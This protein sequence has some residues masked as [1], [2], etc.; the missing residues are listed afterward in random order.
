MGSSI[1][2]LFSNFA[3]HTVKNRLQSICK[4][5]PWYRKWKE[6]EKV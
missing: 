1:S 6:R 4:R 3:D 5:V 2:I